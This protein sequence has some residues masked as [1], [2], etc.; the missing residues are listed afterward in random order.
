MLLWVKVKAVLG[1]GCQAL[2][3]IEVETTMIP[4]GQAKNMWLV[5]RMMW[6]FT[7]M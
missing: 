7:V 2:G 1:R 3:G 5:P 4:N 6:P